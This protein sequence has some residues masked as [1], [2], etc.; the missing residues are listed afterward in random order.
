M[1]KELDLKFYYDQNIVNNSIKKITPFGKNLGY[2]IRIKNELEL[3]EEVCQLLKAG[4]DFGM[5]KQ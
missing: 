5:R 3:T 1:K 2:H 4:F